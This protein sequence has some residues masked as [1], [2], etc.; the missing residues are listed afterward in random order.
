MKV[1]PDTDISSDIEDALCLDHLSAQAEFE[2][3]APSDC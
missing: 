1:L 3:T 2:L